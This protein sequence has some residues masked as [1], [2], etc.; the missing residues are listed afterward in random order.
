MTITSEEATRN[1]AAAYKQASR[2]GY[3]TAVLSTIFGILYLLGLSVNLIVGGTTHSENPAIQLLSATIAIVWLQTLLV[4]FV[5]LRWN[6]PENGRFLAEV[7]LVFMALVCAVS[8]TNWFVRLAVLPRV[9]QAGDQTI[10]NLIDPYNPASIMF[11][12][13]HLGWGVFFGLATLFAG[14]ALSGGRLE[15]WARGLLVTA[16]LL[17][18]LHA[19]GL[20]IANPL[21]S[22]LGYPAWAIL[23]PAA[24]LLLA[25]LFRRTYSTAH[26]SSLASQKGGR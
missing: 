22:F 26:T 6:A 14:F 9:A 11:A 20:V 2:A 7:A 24:T 19:F 15:S 25:F 10:L 8:S 12:M 13:E 5:A 16:G 1:G 18:L 4:L 3:I 17:S 23:L 21:L